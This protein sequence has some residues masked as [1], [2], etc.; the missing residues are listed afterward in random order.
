MNDKK[1]ISI[2]QFSDEERLAVNEALQNLMEKHRQR[3]GKEPDSKKEKELNTEARQQ[4][5][6]DKLL[7]EKLKAEKESKKPVRKKKPSSMAAS[8][9][10]DF[11]W[12]ASVAKGRRR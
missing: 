9:V 4:V 2:D 6:A 7:N 5:M 1:M 10:S 3:T 11:N 8:E 12:S